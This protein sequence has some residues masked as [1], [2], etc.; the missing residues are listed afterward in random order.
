MC[1]LLND[2]FIF[3]SERYMREYQKVLNLGAQRLSSLLNTALSG[4]NPK[5]SIILGS[6]LG[7]LADEIISS[8]E[9]TFEELGL[10]NPHV[11]GH[12]GKFIAGTLGGEPVLLQQGRIHLYEG[13]TGAMSALP[14]RMQMNAGVKNI[15]V[16]NAA[17]Y[18]DP[19][20]E[21][22]QIALLSG[23][24]F[25][26]KGAFHP[27]TG[28]SGEMIGDKFYAPSLGYS[29][30]LREEFYAI[31]E[32][33]G[34]SEHVH[35]E[36]VYVYRYGPNYEEESD[37]WDLYQKRLSRIKEGKPEHAPISV[38]MSTAP[39]ILAVAQFNAMLASQGKELVRC[40]AISNFTNPGAGL[41]E[42]KPT[43]EEVLR[44]SMLGGERIQSVV[45][46]YITQS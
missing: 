9:I 32:K 34:I 14:I 24:D 33:L 37:I 43:H 8:G 42:N 46:K 23:C 29:K 35:K 20:F 26:L 40:V 11:A 28:L 16:T 2:P 13:H 31:A 25:D 30:E 21:T 7:P 1:N 36:G 22:G 27:S 4:K 44:D 10:P 45:K 12:A 41:K 38:G 39:E 18:L 17:G 3:G 19:K 5:L 6:G 15:L